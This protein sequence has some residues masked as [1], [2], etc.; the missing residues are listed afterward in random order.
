M[1]LRPANLECGNKK[2][3]WILAK[4][5]QKARSISKALC[6]PNDIQY[7]WRT[8]GEG[9]L[10]PGCYY[11][12]IRFPKKTTFVPKKTRIPEKTQRVSGV[13][14]F[15]TPCIYYLSLTPRAVI[16]PEN[17]TNAGCDCLCFLRFSICIFGFVTRII[18][19]RTMIVVLNE[20]GFEHLWSEFN[21]LN[22]GNLRLLATAFLRRV[23]EEFV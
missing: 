18:F 22:S 10:R 6:S 12:G 16:C 19:L 20:G 13:P 2:H 7:I 9:N 8:E 11:D 17:E 15:R 4:Q 3:Y 21:Y 14:F 1:I 5:K 23:S